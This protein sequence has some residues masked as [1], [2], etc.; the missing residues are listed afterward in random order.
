MNESKFFLKDFF[1][2][3]HFKKKFDGISWN[4]MEKN[5][6]KYKEQIMKN[7][8]KMGGFADLQPLDP[9]TQEEIYNDYCRY[10]K[11]YK[12]VKKMS[13]RELR[14]LFHIL[15]SNPNE[16]VT[17]GLYDIPDQFNDFLN[18][19]IQKNKQRYLKKL[20]SELLYHYPED[21]NILFDRLNKMYGNLDEKKTSNKLLFEANNR[22][23]L[24]EKSGPLTIAKNIL[25]IKNDLNTLLSDLWITE[26]HLLKG[27]GDKIVRELCQLVHWPL[28]RLTGGAFYQTDTKILERFLEYLSGEKNYN[29]IQPVSNSDISS[30]Q[31]SK[32]LG[33]YGDIQL[34]AK[35][36]LNP[37][38]H[39]DP[40]KSIKTTITQFLDQ[41]I[42][43]PRFSSERWIAMSKEKDIFLRWKIGETIKDFLKLLTYTVKK[44]PNADRMWKYRKEFIKSYWKAGHIKEAWIILGKEAYKDRSKF[45]NKKSDNYGRIIKGVTFLH[46]AL[47]YKI[48]TVIV[49]EWNYNGKVRIW[50]EDNNSS[51]VFYKK[52]YSKMNLTKKPD[53][54]ISHSSPRTYYWQKALSNYIYEYTDI[55]CPENLQKKIDQMQ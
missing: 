2:N 20:I 42:G 9:Q 46:S 37:F 4:T 3:Y 29:V 7:I 14:N 27:I 36:L 21:E 6:K 15:F 38:E 31:S 49:S 53:K 11:K 22:F 18:T 32:A 26:R 19:L 23:R 30:T 33:R 24:L 13:D 5:V 12:T 28:A 52:E 48:D 47:I 34:I 54:Q 35:A 39:K 55:H 25:D 8:K 44:N 10:W 43:D 40:E 16:K 51:P 50:N 45:L 41:H 1:K 17:K